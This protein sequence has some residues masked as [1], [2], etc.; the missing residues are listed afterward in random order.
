MELTREGASLKVAIDATLSTAEIDVLI[1][2]LAKLRAFMDPPVPFD[3]PTSEN[4]DPT[5]E[6]QIQDDPYMAL[7]KVKGGAVRIWLRSGG[8]GWHGFQL[9]PKK[10]AWLRNGLIHFTREIPAVDF[11][12][13]QLAGG[14]ET[15]H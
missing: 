14:D 13:E 9:P 11:L 6:L 1:G 15:E 4:T 7:K 5:R 2:N 12:G 8:T 3:A 10:A